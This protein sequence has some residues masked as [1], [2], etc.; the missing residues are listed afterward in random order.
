VT[1]L[2]VIGFC[3]VQNLLLEIPMLAFKI[4]PT[5]TPDAIH[6]AKAWGARHGTQYGAWGLGILGVALAVISVIGLI[7]R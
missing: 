4:W 2:I 1:V 5:E 3:L 6:S 7:S